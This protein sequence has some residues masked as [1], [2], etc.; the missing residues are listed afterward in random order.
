MLNVATA[1]RLCV[2]PGL[3][4]GRL[5]YARANQMRNNGP[6]T[7]SNTALRPWSMSRRL[8]SEFS[9]SNGMFMP[10]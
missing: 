10:Y 6:P 5:P 7:I 8:L 4:V 9:S 1:V 2:L 3:M